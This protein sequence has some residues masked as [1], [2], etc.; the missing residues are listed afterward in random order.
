VRRDP[1]ETRWLLTTNE[2]DGRAPRIAA[3]GYVACGNPFNLRRGF[4]CSD[5]DALRH[6][7]G[8]DI[9]PKRDQQL[10]CHRHNGD[11]P[12][13]PLQCAD[14]FAEPYRERAVGLVAQPQPG[15]LNE[16]C[17]GSRIPRTTDASIAV[18]AAALVRHRCNADV[19]GKLS[20]VGKRSVE[21]LA[22]QYGGKV[23]SNATDPL[24][25]RDLRV[26]ASLGVA[27]SASLRSVSISRISSKVSTSRRRSRSSSARSNGGSL[28]PSPV[29]SSA[30]SRSHE[31]SDG[32]PRMPCVNSSASIL[33]SSRNL[34]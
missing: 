31:R 21:H 3:C 27:V 22:H 29:R 24:Q 33:F 6:H 23:W 25:G 16:R 9:A 18:H 4:F 7:A 26:V 8:L 19:A 32:L 28:R 10:S 17:A 1:P 11:P 20:A 2:E 14:T 12:G 30:M 15:K 13:A 34:S 5:L